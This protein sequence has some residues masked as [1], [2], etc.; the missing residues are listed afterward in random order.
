MQSNNRDDFPTET[1]SF[2]IAG[3]EQQVEVRSPDG[4]TVRSVSPTAAHW[5]SV[6]GEH[7]A[8]YACDDVRGGTT[9]SV[10][11]EVITENPSKREAAARLAA[12]PL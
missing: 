9:L 4:W 3:S 1:L 10:D 7:T 11:G 5:E 12:H 6:D 8:T 2:E